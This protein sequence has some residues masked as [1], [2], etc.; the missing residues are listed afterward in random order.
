MS[1]GQRS[2]TSPMKQDRA[3]VAQLERQL[4]SPRQGDRPEG[5]RKSEAPE[6]GSRAAA[7]SQS[8]YLDGVADHVSRALL[9]F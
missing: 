8:G 3:P 2:A 7:P 1:E 9:A 4:V 5:A 6:G